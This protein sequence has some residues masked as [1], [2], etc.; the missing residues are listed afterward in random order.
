VNGK[1]ISASKVISS[2]G[3]KKSMDLLPDSEIPA[4]WRDRIH[5]LKGSPAYFCLYIGYEV[6]NPDSVGISKA[7][8][9]FFED[10]L[11]TTWSDPSRTPPVMYVS[12]PSLK[13]PNHTGSSHTAELI[14]FT[15]YSLFKKWK[16]TRRGKRTADYMEF[17]K[18]YELELLSI[19]KKRFPSL[20]D[21]IRVAELATPLSMEFFTKSHQGGI[22]GL[23][24]TVHR[25][26]TSDLHAKTPVKNLY[27]TG[28]DILTP[29]V[30]GAMT[31]GILTAA[32]IDPKLFK[33]L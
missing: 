14:T 18:V 8:H 27:F 16:E 7:N 3:A 23:A 22:Y 13:D 24:S 31:S 5:E 12:F 4:G 32:A 9:W 25:Y 29:G 28:Q 30:V 21:K 20:A 26:L 19:F 2:I 10:S 1:K 15:D 11:E 33:L 6:E 17:K